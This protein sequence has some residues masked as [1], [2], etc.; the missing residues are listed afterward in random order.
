MDVSAPTIHAHRVVLASQEGL[1]Q[2][3]VLSTH[4]PDLDLV[5]RVIH[6]QRVWEPFETR[7]WI[8]SHREG[9]VVLDVGANLGYF[10][11][12][13][14]HS[15]V[16]P[17]LVLA[18][19][20]AADNYAL[21]LRNL[22]ANLSE[23]P[24]VPLHAALAV[25]DSR[26]TL[27]RNDSNLGDHQIY[28][29]DGE[30]CSEAIQLRDGSAFVE[31]HASSIDLVKIDTQGSEYDVVKGLFR[32]M[33]AGGKTLRILIELTPWS[34]R[35]AGSSGRALLEKLEELQL[36][37]AIVDHVEHRLV[38]SSIEALCDWSDNVDA[39]DGDRGFMNVFFGTPPKGL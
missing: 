35:C 39:C 11:L 36:P 5:S 22:E 3:L 21:L 14:I 23:V 19:E 13:S 2:E 26:A 16:R 9:D 24:A 12:L 30:R 28:A 32:V 4:H 17:S 18:A 10:T 37:V 15:K 20:P 7:L 27:H 38:P 33:R 8:A 25:N 34:L 6:D 1:R 29:G 31:Q